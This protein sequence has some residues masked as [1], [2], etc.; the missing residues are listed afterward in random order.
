M[1]YEIL[2]DGEQYAIE[3]SAGAAAGEWRCLARSP[4]SGEV[5]EITLSAVFSGSDVLSLLLEGK[6]LTARRE[7]GANQTSGGVVIDGHRH[8]VDVRDPR[9]LRSRRAAAGA[10][11][12]PKKILAPMPGKIVRVVAAVGSAVEAGDGVIVIE[13]MKMQNELKS[14]KKGTVQKILVAEGSPV[15][16]GDALAIV[17]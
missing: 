4:K 8:S 5:R 10:E 14:P 1:N 9:S 12:G 3:M 17:E 2:V 6:S 16:A 7:I 15:N 11:D 13:A